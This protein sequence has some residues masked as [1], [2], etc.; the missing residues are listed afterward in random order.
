MPS[1]K[2]L[3]N[4]GR[5]LDELA[6][7]DA[8]QPDAASRHLMKTICDWVGAHQGIFIGAV[9]VIRGAT[10][11][12]DPLNGWRAR[13]TIYLH[14]SPAR[15]RRSLRGMRAQD[16]C[17]PVTSVAMAARAGVFRMHRLHD[18]FVN[19]T[20]FKRTAHCQSFYVDSGLSDRMWIAIP[21]NRDTECYFCFD[22]QRSRKHFTKAEMELAG[23]ALR[24]LKWFYRQLLLHQGLLVVRKVLSPAERKIVSLLLTDKSEKEIA[25]KLGQT[26][27]TLHRHVTEIFRRFGVHGRAGLMALWL[28]KP[29]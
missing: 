26:F 19:L 1:P 20:V 11:Q 17:P 6:D 29:N 5:L 8:T 12:R 4:I 24:G 18:G 28:G 14:P 2:Q 15:K 10:A 22:R 7:F 27:N 13:A 21:V 16:T 23:C 25:A 3:E 9:R